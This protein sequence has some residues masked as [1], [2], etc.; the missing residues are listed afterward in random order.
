M[1][2]MRNMFDGRAKLRPLDN[3]RLQTCGEADAVARREN[4]W[5][6]VEAWVGACLFATWLR[7]C[8]WADPRALIGTTVHA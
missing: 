5:L 4:R 2:Y 1:Q 6:A 8:G 7:H 3:E